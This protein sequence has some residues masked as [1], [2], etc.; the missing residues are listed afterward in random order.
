MLE[1]A[2]DFV[3]EVEGR[4]RIPIHS[5][6]DVVSGLDPVLVPSIV[7]QRLECSFELGQACEFVSDDFSDAGLEEELESVYGSTGLS[8][9]DLYRSLKGI[10]TCVGT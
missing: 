7:S 1:M 9:F 8:V 10:H 4:F 6:H 3:L 2:L 5:P